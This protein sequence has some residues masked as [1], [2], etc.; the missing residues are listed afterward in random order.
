MRSPSRSRSARPKAC[1]NATGSSQRP[2]DTRD[3][4]VARFAMGQLAGRSLPVAA[5]KFAEQLAARL[6]LTWPGSA[7]ER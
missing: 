7:A 1:A 2:I 6:E 5:A 4:P 3:I